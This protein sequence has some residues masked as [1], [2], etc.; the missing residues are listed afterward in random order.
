MKFYLI[1]I[2][3]TYISKLKQFDNYVDAE[4]FRQFLELKVKGFKFKV[5]EN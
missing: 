5:F 4:T 2:T 1:M 3:K